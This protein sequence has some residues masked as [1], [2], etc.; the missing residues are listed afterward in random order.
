MSLLPSTPTFRTATP[1]DIGLLQDLAE[2]IWPVSY[3]GI[4]PPAQ[5]QYM[6]DWMYGTARI[7]AELDAGLVWEVV[8]LEARPLGFLSWEVVPQLPVKLHKLY[9]LPAEQGRGLGQ[10]MLQHVFAQAGAIGASGVELTVN[11]RNERA[12][13]AYRRAGFAVGESACTDIGGGYFMDDWI[14]RRTL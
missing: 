7:A 6:L 11:K 3:A 9:L 4:L 2:S 1:A 12:L 14:L 8:E 5:I 13:R 10:V